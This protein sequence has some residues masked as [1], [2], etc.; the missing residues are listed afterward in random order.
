MK[1]KINRFIY[2]FFIL[3]GLL[4]LLMQQYMATVSLLGLGILFDPFN[5][6]QSWSEKPFWQ[7]VVFLVQGI[8]VMGLFVPV[9]YNL[10]KNW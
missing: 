3:V 2:S 10:L 1:T 8:I 7:K 6:N 4:S 5:A 9:M